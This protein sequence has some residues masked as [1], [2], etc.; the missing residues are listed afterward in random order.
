MNQSI[1]YYERQAMIVVYHDNCE[2]NLYTDIK[3]YIFVFSPK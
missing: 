2:M 3:L 1:N